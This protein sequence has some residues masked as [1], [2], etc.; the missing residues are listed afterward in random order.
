MTQSE[1][2][3]RT[4]STMMESSM[5]VSPVHRQD[6]FNPFTGPAPSTSQFSSYAPSMAPNAQYGYNWQQVPQSLPHSSPS[7][8][9]QSH[10]PLTHYDSIPHQSVPPST[11]YMVPVQQRTDWSYNKPINTVLPSTEEPS[12]V[13]TETTSPRQ[14]VP[15]LSSVS[16]ISE[17]SSATAET[18]TNVDMLVRTIQAKANTKSEQTSAVTSPATQEKFNYGS[19]GSQSPSSVFWDASARGSANP[20]KRYQCDIP[21]CAK[22]F[23]QKTHLDIHMRAHTGHKPFVC[24]CVRRLKGFY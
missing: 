10:V 18:N 1:D 2:A 15:P 5:M 16:S 12:Y 11:S 24:C 22:S 9:Y 17:P 13:K 8:S 7:Y 20:R 21:S 6:R 23:F 14:N 19:L 3:R 4:P